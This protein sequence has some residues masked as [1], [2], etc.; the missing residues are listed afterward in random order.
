[1]ERLGLF[2]TVDWASISEGLFK[3]GQKRREP[4][5][6]GPPAFAAGGLKGI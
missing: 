1:M 6:E 5:V 2:M 4:K 3:E